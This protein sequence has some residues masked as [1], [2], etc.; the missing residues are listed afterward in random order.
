[1]GSTAGIFKMLRLSVPGTSQAWVV[2][3]SIG[4]SHKEVEMLSKQMNYYKEMLTY[5]QQQ[6]QVLEQ[7]RF[8]VQGSG[9]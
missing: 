1:M 3:E 2:S 7:Q 8:H 4:V 9:L 6:I 5:S